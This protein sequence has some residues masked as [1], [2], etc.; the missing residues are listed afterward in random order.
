[1]LDLLLE[2]K[3]ININH[4]GVC[5][6]TR[7]CVYVCIH[8]IIEIIYLN[9]FYIFSFF[10]YFSYQIREGDS[11]NI[12]VTSPGATIALGL[13]YFNTGNRAVAE[14][15]Q[16]PDTQYLLDFVRP[17]FLLLRILAKSLI[18]WNEIEPTKS[19]VSSHVP[20][21]VYK[22]R[23]QKPTSEIGQNVDLETMK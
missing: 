17:D 21:I 14:W 12:D 15:M 16:A 11:I 4:L 3:K 9:S 20:N 5:V 23:L 19:W 8:V 10:Y 2:H 13:M 1:M 6:C 18:L 22:Y 7:A